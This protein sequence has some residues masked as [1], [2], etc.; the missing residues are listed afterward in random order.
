M[1]GA[2]ELITTPGVASGRQ[3]SPGGWGAWLLL[4][5]LCICLL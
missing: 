2:P 4:L 5:L 1:V 3:I